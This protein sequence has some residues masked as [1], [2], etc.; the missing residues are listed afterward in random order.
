MYAF[1]ILDNNEEEKKCKGVTKSI[2]KYKIC[3]K[4]VLSRDDDKR[5]IM[6]DWIRTLARGHSS[7]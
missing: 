6:R 7:I 5:I 3:F 1:K 2:V 4:M